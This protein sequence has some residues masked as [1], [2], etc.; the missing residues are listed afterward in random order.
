MV[1]DILHSQQHNS[2]QHDMLPQHPV[3]K[4]ELDS[5]CYNITLSRKNI[6]SWWWS[7]KIETCRS[8][9]NCFMWNLYKCKC[10]LRIEAILQNARCNNNIY[11]W[12]SLESN[13]RAYESVSLSLSL[14]LSLS[15]VHVHTVQDVC[16]D[17]MLNLIRSHCCILI[18][19][20]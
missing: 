4:N 11:R 7:E 12:L 10:W 17:M 9:F 2:T 19:K 15:S 3:Y 5:E 18:L 16:P 14:S 20:I 6:A 8:V 13:F 1:T